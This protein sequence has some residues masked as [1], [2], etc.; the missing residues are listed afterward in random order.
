MRIFIFLISCFSFLISTNA[1]APVQP[2]S[3]DLYEQIQK[4]QVLGSVLY[5][6]AHPDDENTRMI[7]YLA[8]EKKVNTAY[9][10]LTRG[11]GGQNLIGPEIRDLLGVI[12]TQE[13]LK[14]RSVDGGQ[15]F[16]SRANDFGYSK[17]PEET[18]KIWDEEEVMADVVWAIRKFQ[19]DVIINRFDHSGNRRTHGHHTSSAV[20]SHKAFDL[21]GNKEVYPEQLEHVNTWQPKRLFFNT[22][23]WFFGS[24]EKFAKADK[25]DMLSVDVGVYYP[26]KGKSN[27]EIAAES[28]SMHKCQG[29]GSTGKRGSE[30]E[31]LKLLK[32]EM[33]K[34]KSSIFEGINTTW[35]RV[36]GGESIG[37]VIGNVDAEFKHENPAA[38]IP[39]LMA[40]YQM[41]Q[42][43]PDGYWK[44]VKLKDIKISR[45]S[46]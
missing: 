36:K 18:L 29:F 26:M 11:D 6:A 3:A 10:S 5:V 45:S 15:Q 16:F 32:G 8:N 42:G 12:R 1:Q 14:A 2:T 21:V 27:N 13:L 35:T 43:L 40:A 31:Y 38:S 33:P 44:S 4:M 46:C 7:S 22:S 34:D 25:S 19:P 41:I 20:L 30:Q 23:W 9:L 24:R 17:N 28:R 39:Q 37:Q